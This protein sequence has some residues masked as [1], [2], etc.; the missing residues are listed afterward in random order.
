MRNVRYSWYFIPVCLI[1]ACLGAHPARAEVHVEDLKIGFGLSA[2]G[3]EGNYKVGDWAPARVRLRTDPEALDGVLELSTA[4]SDDVQTHFKHRVHLAANETVEFRT[5]VKTGKMVSAITVRV[6]DDA[7]KTRDKKEFDS[8]AGDFALPSPQNV[9]LLVTLGRPAGLTLEEIGRRPGFPRDSFRV[10]FAESPRDLPARWFGYDAVDQLILCTDNPELIENL[11]IAAQGA[12]EAWVRHGGH[13]VVSLGSAGQRVAASFLGPMLPADIDGAESV[14]QLRE[15]ESYV[16]SSSPL[17]VQGALSVPRFANVRGRILVGPGD[18]PLAV[19]GPYGLGTVTAIGLD[20]NREPFASWE[21]R[22]DFWLKLLAIRKRPAQAPGSAG[23]L[24]QSPWNDFSSHLR[25]QLEHFSGISLVPFQWV[26]FFIFLYI[27]LIGPVDYWLVK[28]VFRR[29]ELTW[30]TF[31]ALVIG[32]SLAAYFAAYWLKGDELRINKLD[33]V[34]VDSGTGTLRGTSW[35]ALFSPQIQTYTVGLVPEFATQPEPSDRTAAPPVMV[36]WLGL[37][38]NTI[39]GM[40]RQGGIGL[41]QKGYAFGPDA[42]TLVDVPVQVWSIKGFSGRWHGRA[43]A[44]LEAKLE[45]LGTDWLRG[46]VRNS[47]AVPLEDATLVF[48]RWAYPLG[49]IP[50]GGTESLETHNREDLHGHLARRA[51]PYVGRSGGGTPGA[52]AAG[53]DPFRPDDLAFIMMFHARLLQAGD[54]PAN[55]YFGDIDLS[56]QLDYNRAIL[57]ARVPAS[58]SELRLN[59]HAAGGAVHEHTLLRVVMPV[60]A[61]APAPYI[62]RPKL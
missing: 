13:L 29:M 30:L 6:I 32:V 33:V 37:A 16:G 24:N 38:E 61:G 47:L 14:T 56:E 46:T 4:D 15:L 53:D 43:G 36:S 21:A 45:S 28:K 54:Y 41:F 10:A 58:G 7:G 5:F 19:Q 62:E 49:T 18:R 35:I 1:A 31:P 26:A 11:D 44:T 55:D 3:E 57:V 42:Q 39:G 48:G 51:A 2:T 25:Q 12:I 9:M 8:G 34:D 59:D 50:P 22:T 40:G 20:V 60:A 52:A 23:G 17:R 27:L